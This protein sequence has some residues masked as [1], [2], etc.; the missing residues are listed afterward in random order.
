MCTYLKL[1]LY[2][3]VGP[4]TL[5]KTCCTHTVTDVIMRKDKFNSVLN[6]SGIADIDVITE[7]RAISSKG[8]EHILIQS[9][10]AASESPGCCQLEILFAVA[11]IKL[12]NRCLE[13]F[14]F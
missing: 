9:Y 4:F 10:T 12:A 14:K 7:K 6:I 5:R 11:H 2:P 3:V 8:S 1:S 13:V